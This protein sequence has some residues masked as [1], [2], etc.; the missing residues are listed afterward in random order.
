MG[1]EF[2]EGGAVV[3]QHLNDV[4]DTEE[5]VADFEDAKVRERSGT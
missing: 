2:L 4:F 1:C 5:C 3:L